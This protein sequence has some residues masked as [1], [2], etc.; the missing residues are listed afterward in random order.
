[1]TF[2]VRCRFQVCLLFYVQHRPRS[3]FPIF[4]RG[5]TRLRFRSSSTKV[6]SDLLHIRGHISFPASCTRPLPAQGRSPTASNS[7]GRLSS[8]PLLWEW[9]KVF[10]SSLGGE[11][12]LP[13]PHCFFGYPVA[14]GVLQ[15]GMSTFCPASPSVSGRGGSGSSSPSGHCPFTRRQGPG[16]FG[17]SVLAR[18]LLVSSGN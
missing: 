15:G 12:S 2:V 3:P 1:M 7:V 16:P 18:L 11:R 4:G 10:L 6:S 13:V 8:S 5:V 9:A 14:R 17:S